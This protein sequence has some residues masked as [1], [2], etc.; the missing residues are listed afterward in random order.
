MEHDNNDTPG[1][2]T[3]KRRRGQSL[4]LDLSGNVSEDLPAAAAVFLVLFDNKK[5]QV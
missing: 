1:M 5:G 3:V 4:H 2:S